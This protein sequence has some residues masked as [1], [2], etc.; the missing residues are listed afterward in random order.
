[1]DFAAS[2]NKGQPGMPKRRKQLKQ[3]L[4][5]SKDYEVLANLF[6][7]ELLKGDEERK[8]WIDLLLPELNN[9]PDIP[10]P[11]AQDDASQHQP[12]V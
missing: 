4:A 10:A 3:A 6:N 11:P 5:Q 7:V 2:P 8:D 9:L 12:P 1:M